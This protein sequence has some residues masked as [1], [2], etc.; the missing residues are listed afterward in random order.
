MASRLPDHEQDGLAAAIRAE[1]AADQR[2]A[3]LL[4]SSVKTLENLADEALAEHRENRTK[5]LDP[6]K[7]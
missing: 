1:I 3:V 5:L 2:W 6:D 4:A 7:L